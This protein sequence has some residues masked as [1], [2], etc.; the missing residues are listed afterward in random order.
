MSGDKASLEESENFP[1]PDILAQ[2]IVEDLETA[3][4]QFQEIANDLGVDE[5]LEDIK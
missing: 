2:S 1:E 3:L 5:T 4:E